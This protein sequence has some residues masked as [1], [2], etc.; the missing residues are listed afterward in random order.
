MRLSAFL[1]LLIT[2]HSVRADTVYVRDTLYVPIRGGQS[3]EHRILHSGVRS[4]TQLEHLEENDDTKY[5]KVRMKSGLEGWIQ[6]Q[7]LVAEPIAEDQV[8][9]ANSQVARLK[10][11]YR[12]A[13]LQIDEFKTTSNQLDQSRV[14]LQ[15]ENQELS[16][17]LERITT[18]AARVIAIDDENRMLKEEQASLLRNIYSLDAANQE[19]QDDS[20]ESWFLRGV[21]TVLMGLLFGFWVARRIYQKR[22]SGGWA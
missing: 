20:N 10:E 5:S 17:E 4:G 9:D 12:V 18:L 8:K 6:T 7:Y 3:S 14:E 15:A 13:L 11:Q 2:I 21:G 19:L 16:E 22:S 1:L